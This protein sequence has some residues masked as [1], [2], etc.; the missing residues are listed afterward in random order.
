MRCASIL[1]LGC[2]LA[3]CQSLHTHAPHSALDGP[4]LA[5]VHSIYLDDLDQQEGADLIEK[6]GMVR[7]HI[8]KRLAKSGRF[9]VVQNP[10]QADA[11]LTGLAGVELWYHGMEGYYGMEGDMD[12]HEL[13]IGT[14]RLLDAKTKQPIWT[15][16]YETGLLSPKQSV[17]E[18]VADQMVDTLVQDTLHADKMKQT[19]HPSY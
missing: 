1:F 8:R 18:R 14:L 2:W 5:S 6:S 3:A 10:E 15:H 7:D 19:S 12:N 17:I 9:S 16:E 11:I 4:G 13:G